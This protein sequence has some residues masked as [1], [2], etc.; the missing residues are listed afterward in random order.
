[1]KYLKLW[2]M[3]I[4]A[5]LIFSGCVAKNQT[6]QADL[7]TKA[8]QTEPVLPSLDERIQI[9]V[10]SLKLVF[11]EAGTFMMGADAESPGHKVILTRD[12]FISAYEI[13]FDLYDLYCE[14][15]QKVK[16]KDEGWGR[17]ERPVMWVSWLN[18]KDFCNWLSINSGL[19]P[20]YSGITCDFSKNGYRL[21]S[22]AEWEFAARGG[23]HSRN[24]IY[25]GSDVLDEVGWYSENTE[26]TQAVGQ[27]KPNELGIY[28]MSGNLFEFCNDWYL[29]GYYEI[30]P[31]INPAGPMRTEIDTTYGGKRV[32]R[33]SN[34]NYDEDSARVVHRSAE[35]LKGKD[36]GMGFRI[37][38]NAM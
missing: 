20:C 2:G 38:R 21:P 18:A 33:G 13:T 22:E 11:V 14:S 23:K 31:E 34:F 26:T 35:E 25:S 19:D 6:I 37:V 16:P 9:S 4:F 36:F 7:N 32:R 28:D 15:A 8:V 27:K 12:Y 17:G 3:L 30:S 29:K 10:N 24:F 1:M 5:V